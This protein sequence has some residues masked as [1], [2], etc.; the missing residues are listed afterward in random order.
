MICMMKINYKSNAR[1]VKLMY[2]VISAE[3]KQMFYLNMAVFCYFFNL[4][5]FL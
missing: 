5:F 4:Q 1:I 3:N 2:H